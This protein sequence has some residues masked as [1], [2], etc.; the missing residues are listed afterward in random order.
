MDF[1][2][3]IFIDA[4]T[5]LLAN[6]LIT[7]AGI[8][9]LARVLGCEAATFNITLNAVA[10]SFIESEITNAITP[11]FSASSWGQFL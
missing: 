10:I 11:P 6:H 9:G 2:S 5:F 4:E 1:Q 7:K 3:N 8:E